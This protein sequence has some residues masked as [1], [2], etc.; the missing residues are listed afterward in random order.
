MLLVFRICSTFLIEWTH[1]RVVWSIPQERK[2]KPS[3]LEHIR[4]LLIRPI[5]KVD[6]WFEWE[7]APEKEVES[8]NKPKQYR[9]CQNASN[10][11]LQFN[12]DIKYSLWDHAYPPAVLNRKNWEVIR[13]CNCTL[14]L[15]K[16]IRNKK[17]MHISSNCLPRSGKRT[18]MKY[19]AAAQFPMVCLVND[20]FSELGRMHSFKCL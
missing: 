13:R 2:L 9:K 18:D 5:C 1:I 6:A 10:L 19:V 4:K 12:Y 16:E 11:V 8:L 20:C 14:E 15:R 17:W 3:Y 7:V